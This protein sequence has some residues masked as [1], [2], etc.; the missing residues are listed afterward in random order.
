MEVIIYGT[1]GHSSV[2]VDALLAKGN[3]SIRCL[4]DDDPN[5]WGKKLNRFS[6]ISPKG[7]EEEISRAFFFLAI[8]DNDVRR[9]KAMELEKLGAKFLSIIHPK[10]IVSP[11]AQI[12]AGTLVGGSAVVNPYTQVG[13]HCIINTGA[14]VEHHCQIADFVHIAPNATLG[15]EV[16]IGEGTLIGL[17][18]TVLRGIKIGENCV[19]GAGAVVIHDVPSHTTVV[20][21]PAK[22]IER[23]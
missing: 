3:A 15:G 12:G 11:T 17:S 18:A 9:R 21:I 14:I 19:I 20:G 8:G 4:M 13:R 2:V 16:C 7:L 23:R 1:G 6:V 10:A 5:K 22:P